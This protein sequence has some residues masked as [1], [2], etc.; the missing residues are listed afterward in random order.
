VLGV[1]EFGGPVKLLFV[2]S[3]MMPRNRRTSSVTKSQSLPSLSPIQGKL[4]LAE[5]GQQGKKVPDNIASAEKEALL[6]PSDN[7]TRDP[8]PTDQA[9]GRRT[10]QDVL[11]DEG[12]AAVKLSTETESL[13][14]IQ[15]RIVA[16]LK[17]NSTETR[18]RYARSVLKWFF[19][20]GIH[21][22]ARS[23]WIAYRNERIEMDILRYMYLAAEPVMGLCVA[24]SLYPLQPG[25]LIPPTYFDRFLRDFFSEQ[26][27]AKTTARLKS[28]LMRLGFLERTPGKPDRLKSMAFDKTSFLILVHY[29]FA[30]ETPHTVEMSRLLTDP[31]WKY[32]GCKAEDTVRAL[33]READAAGLLGKYVVADQLEQVTTCFTL[34]EFLNRGVRL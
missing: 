24:E 5:S 23:V 32:L 25:M 18:T 14:D 11:L 27:P 4:W 9:H 7:G 2:N 29:L 3:R 31:F 6:R 28:N 1:V 12:L 19:P 20:A 21:S 13:A 26:S 17:Q 10:I 16:E 22:L 30:P 33:L 8:D 15:Q 34:A